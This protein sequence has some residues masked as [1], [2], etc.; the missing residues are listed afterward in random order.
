MRA[1]DVEA[2]IN[3]M[4][5]NRCEAITDSRKRHRSRLGRPRVSHH[6]LSCFN[7]RS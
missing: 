3:H 1:G 7:L 4:A 2:S 5:V 6:H